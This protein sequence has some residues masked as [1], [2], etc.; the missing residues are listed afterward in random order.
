MGKRKVEEIKQPLQ[1][2]SEEQHLEEGPRMKNWPKRELQV[3]WRGDDWRNAPLEAWMDVDDCGCNAAGHHARTF[4]HGLQFAL[5]DVS[6][7]LDVMVFAHADNGP[8]TGNSLKKRY[9]EW[10]AKQGECLRLAQCLNYFAQM[11]IQGR[12]PSLRLW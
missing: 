10:A 6:E 2:E 12:S 11:E 3:R 1:P 5:E 4:L 9:A 7:Q 8:L